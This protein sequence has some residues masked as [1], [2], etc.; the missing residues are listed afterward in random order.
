MNMHSKNFSA[1]QLKWLAIITMTV[2]HFGVLVLLPFSQN[3][4]ISTLYFM[5]RL[6][7][8]LAFPLFGFMIAEGIFRSKQPWRYIS[9]LAIMGVLIGLSMFILGEIGIQALSGNIFIDL[10]MAA[11]AMNLFKQKSLPLRILAILPIGYVLMTSFNDQIPNYLSADYGIYGLMMMLLFFLSYLKLPNFFY[12]LNWFKVGKMELTL[13]QKRYQFASV[14]LIAM[15][16][17]WY[18]IR[19]VLM[20]GFNLSGLVV[21]YINRFVGG[22]SFAVFAAYFIF[23]YRGVKGA[24]PKW[25][26]WF[27]YLYY[28]LHFV[29]LYAIYYVV[30]L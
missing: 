2:D 19:L 5:A 21:D 1:Y 3:Q 18:I 4:T 17:L 26:Q 29:V 16:I 20:D 15:H 7:G 9:R 27:S 22:Q 8:R 25:F 6:I 23:Q 12:Q 13:E 14:V 30:S 11:L 24:S 10:T 28:P